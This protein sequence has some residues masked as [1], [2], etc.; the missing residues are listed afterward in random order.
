[1]EQ[2]GDPPRG[3]NQ[4]LPAEC[5]AKVKCRDAMPVELAGLN[6]DQEALLRKLNERFCLAVVHDGERYR[7]RVLADDAGPPRRIR[8]MD[9]ETFACIQSNA[10]V[11]CQVSASRS[12]ALPIARWWLQNSKAAR[13]PGVV[14]A[15]QVAAAGSVDELLAAM[16]TEALEELT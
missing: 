3:R 4:I 15:D 2:Y 6:R 16:E 5:R 14:T 1:M 9:Y 10:F 7:K 12:T 11:C 13:V 8:V